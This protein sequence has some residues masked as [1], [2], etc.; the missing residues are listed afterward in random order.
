MGKKSLLRRA[1]EVAK[2]CNFIDR[3]IVSTDD[4]NIKQEAIKYGAEVYIRPLHLAGDKSVIIDT[5]RH[6]NKVLIS[7]GSNVDI[8]ILLEPTSPFRDRNLIKK[9]ID[10]MVLK[11]LDSIA[12]FHEAEIHP[13]K[14]WIIKNNKPVTFVKKG[15]PWTPRQSLEKIYQLNGLVYAFNPNKI[16]INSNGLLFASSGAE[17]VDNTKVIDIDDEKDLIIA[18]VMLKRFT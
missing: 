12:T 7:E 4:I 13:Q 15:N 5:I 8:M 14:T 9:C 11:K 2:D 1:I 16:P 10:K 6:V 18:N 3:V 17:I